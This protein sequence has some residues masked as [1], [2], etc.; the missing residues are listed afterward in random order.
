MHVPQLSVGLEKLT[1]DKIMSSNQIVMVSVRPRIYQYLSYRLQGNRETRAALGY[2]LL[3]T[4]TVLS[5][6][7]TFHVHP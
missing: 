7:A 4:I 3:P 6:L 1:C 2:R 5:H